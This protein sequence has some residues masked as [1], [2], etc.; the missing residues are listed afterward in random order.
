MSG[1]MKVPTVLRAA[2]SVSLSGL[3]LSACSDASPHGEDLGSAGEAISPIPGCDYSFARPSPASL[4]SLGYKF[5]ARYLSGDPGGGKDLTSS[6]ASSLTAAGLDIVLVWETTGTD[7]TNGYN[8]GVSDATGAKNEAAAVGQPS[9]RPI[10]FAIDF[11]ATS[12]DAASINAYFQGVASVIG[13]SRTGVYGGYYIVNELFNAGRVTFAWQTYAWS[14][15]SWDSRAQLRQT[16]N[17][18]DGDQ[19]DDDEGMVADFGQWGPG[20]PASAPRGYLDTASCTTVGGWT[21]YEPTPAA[22]INADV[23]FNAAAGGA[24]AEGF[25]LVAG[26]NRADLCTAINSCDHGYSMPTPRGVM[27][28]TA[29]PVFAYGINPVAGGPNTLLTGSPKQ[30]TCAAPAI[31]SG[32]VKRHVTS[33][34]ILT[35]WRFNTFLDM[36]PYTTAEVAAVP[37][38]VDLGNPPDVVQVTGQPAIYVEDGTYRRHIINPDSFA[39]WRL[40]AADVKAI[41]AADLAALET[42]PDWPATPLLIKDPGAPAVYM[43][44]VPFPASAAGGDGGVADGGGFVVTDGGALADGGVIQG[45]TPV[46]DGGTLIPPTSD[47][48]TRQAEGNPGGGP[49]TPVG[50]SGGCAVARGAETSRGGL[51]GL[52]GGALFLVRRRRSEGE[53]PSRYSRAIAALRPRD[54]RS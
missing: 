26:N 51:W 5:A 34:T 36:A 33:P 32:D 22:A 18:V 13:L 27:D 48:S 47:A 2:A 38:G 19:L 12:A 41:S 40:T 8:Q 24:G 21:Q 4:V 25:R 6:E 44:D 9:T 23:Y 29:H 43:L 31:P 3:L 39:A 1:S 49:A 52:M 16:Q 15:G 20:A 50:A 28:G 30:L 37:D 7:A 46:S 54:A 53:T 35:D 14:G 11:D 17:G 42:G 45:P 10:Y